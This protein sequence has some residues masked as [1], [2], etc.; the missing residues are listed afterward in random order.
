MGTLNEASSGAPEAPNPVPK[1]VEEDDLYTP[2]DQFTP[3]QRKVEYL[4][5]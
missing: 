1:Y 5:R 2:F 3:I 4:R